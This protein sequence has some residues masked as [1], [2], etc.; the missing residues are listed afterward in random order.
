MIKHIDIGGKSRPVLYNINA[1][2]EFEELTGYEILRNH[3]QM[4]MKSLKKIRALAFV[5]LKH[6]AKVDQTGETFTIE[7]VGEWISFQDESIPN[8]RTA[9]SE[10]NNNETESG[11]STG[12]DE[13]K[14]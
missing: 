8:I 1:L 4:D 5:G 6:G 13:P 12:E 7:Q 3:L 10:A 11:K 14:N 2:I 9:F